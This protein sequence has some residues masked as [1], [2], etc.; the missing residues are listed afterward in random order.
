M[1]PSFLNLFMNKL[2][3][4]RVVPT[5]S[6]SVFWLIFGMTA[7]GFPSLPK[8]AS[9]RSIRARRLS[10]ELN[11]WSIRSASTRRVRVRRYAMNTS[12]NAD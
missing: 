1:K 8:F 12:E 5:M 9:S 2:T 11:N 10:L 3:R 7:S 4:D 6:A